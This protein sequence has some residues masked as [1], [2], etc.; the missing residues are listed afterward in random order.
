MPKLKPFDGHGKD[1]WVD[2]VV[3]NTNILVSGMLSP[4][5]PPGII[6]DWLRIGEIRLALD[7]RIL[8]EYNEVLKRPHF[9]IPSEDTVTLI[10]LIVST[11]SWPDIGSRHHIALPDPDDEPF[12]ECAMAEGVPLVTGNIKHF[13]KSA[14]K[15]IRIL[16]PRQ[17]V[18]ERQGN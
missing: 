16:S 2:A 14:T 7:D 1:S 5:G 10:E 9:R 18:S 11:A 8:G 15:G 3:L 4:S 6:L 12:A 17:Y 13:P